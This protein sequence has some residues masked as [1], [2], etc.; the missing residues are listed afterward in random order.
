[1][2]DKKFKQLRDVTEILG[3]FMFKDMKGWELTDESD[4][5]YCQKK[6]SFLLRIFLVN[7]TKSAISPDLVTFTE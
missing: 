6:L 4:K 5:V 2:K 1:M 7:M 3:H